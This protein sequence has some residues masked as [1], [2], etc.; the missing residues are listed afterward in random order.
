MS[1]PAASSPRSAFDTTMRLVWL[2][3]LVK[4]IL[5]TWF[6]GDYGYFRDELGYIACGMRPD[7]GYVDQPPLIPWLAELSRHLFGESLRAVRFLPALATSLLVVQAALLARE[8]GARRYATWLAA[9]CVALA[10]QYLS[11]GGLLGT[12]CLEPNLWTACALCALRAVKNEDGRQWLWFGLY[13][14]IGLL[15]KY[16]IALFGAAV[17]V[18][19]LLTPQRR[20]LLDRRMWLGGVIALVVFVPNLWWNIHYDWPFLQLMRAIRDEGRDVVLS[21]PDWFFNQLLLVNPLTAPLWMG[22][23]VALLVAPA[24]RPYRFLG[25]AYLVCYGVLFALH[26][27]AYYLAPVY[28]L[29]LAAGAVAFE[30]LLD[31]EAAQPRRGWVKASAASVVAATGLYLAPVTVPVFSP[32]RFLD[33][34]AHLPFKLPVNEHSHARAKLPQWYADQFGWREIADATA[35]A[36]ARVPAAQ[37]ADCGIFAQD[38]GQAGAIDFFGP[39]LGLPRALSGDRSY[40]LWGAQG[41]S[42]DCMIVLDDDKETLE[43]YWSDVEFVTTSAPNPWALEQQLSV[44]LCRGKKIESLAALWPQLKRWR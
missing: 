12:N 32:E 42:G 13:A 26:G 35:L 8:F 11:N 17:V 29:L 40:F 43:K 24:W 20:W 16:T 6:N 5:H 44:H 19:L 38:Y 3:A 4:L 39:Q 25:I 27:K 21:A 30:Q 36:W 31:G 9:L 23:L 10:P 22:G 1:T 33:Y 18:G 14:G 34:A 2:L 15:E 7:F 37:R 41:Y 28:P